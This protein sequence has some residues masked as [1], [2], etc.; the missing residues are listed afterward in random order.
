[1]DGKPRS[2]RAT[3]TAA[4]T[5]VLPTPPLPIVRTTPCRRGP[6]PQPV[7]PA[8]GRSTGRGSVLAS[9]AARPVRRKQARR[10]PRPAGSAGP[11]ARRCE[12]D[13]P[14]R[15]DPVAAPPGSAVPAPGATGSFARR[16]DEHAVD[17]Q[18]L[19]VHASAASS[20]L[21]RSASA[22]AAA[23]GRLTRTSVVIGGVAQRLY[24]VC[25]RAAA[26]PAA[27]PAAPGRKCR[28]CCLVMKPSQAD[29]SVSS[30]KVCPVGAVSKMT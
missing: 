22:S 19:I 30:R 15:R 25:D 6:A 7:R 16:G 13:G 3:A 5:V 27:R 10:H 4:A 9:M 14:A 20:P 18:V 11:A 24:R 28:S 12:A 29:G 26:G 8:C 23:S 1:M 21:V 2:A 17:N